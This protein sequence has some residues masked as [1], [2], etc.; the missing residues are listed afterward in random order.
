VISEQIEPVDVFEIVEACGPP[1]DIK[2]V[3]EIIHAMPIH[4]WGSQV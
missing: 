2:I 3:L 1:E 4:S